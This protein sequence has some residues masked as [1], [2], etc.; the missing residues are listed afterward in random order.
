MTASRMRSGRWTRMAVS[1][2]VPS[3]TSALATRCVSR[4]STRACPPLR[5][6]R[7]SSKRSSSRAR[8]ARAAWAPPAGRAPSA[9]RSVTDRSRTFASAAHGGARL[10][11]LS[12][13]ASGVGARR[14][15]PPAR[16]SSEP[17]V[18]EAGS[19]VF[20]RSALKG[21]QGYSLSK[22]REP[23]PVHSVR[24]LSILR[25]CPQQVSFTV[26]NRLDLT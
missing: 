18:T 23:R 4:T 10:P 21:V 19:A 11:L 16:P 5:G 1:S 24:G 9:A 13:E 8:A 6:S 7:G 25:S 3:V 2:S 12:R 20:I 15:G 14:L 17:A 26:L 22:S